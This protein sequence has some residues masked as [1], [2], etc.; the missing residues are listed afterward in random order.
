M[1]HIFCSAAF[2]TK[3]EHHYSRVHGS[4][5]EVF[6]EVPAYFEP[7]AVEEGVHLPTFGANQTVASHLIVDT[8]H[9][10]RINTS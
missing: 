3:D 6:L 8:I 7:L 10:L 5:G 2:D 4:F 9:Q 1:V